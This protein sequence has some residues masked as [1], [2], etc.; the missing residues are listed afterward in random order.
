MAISFVAEAHGTANYQTSISVSKPTG[1]T[2]GDV[3]IAFCGGSP[4]TP[5][6]WT[7][8]GSANSGTNS[9]RTVRLFRKVASGEGSSYTFSISSSIACASIVSYRG[10]SNTTPVDTAHFDIS[11]IGATTNFNTAS[12]TAAT[13]QWGV[14]FAMAYEYGSSSTRTW[15]EGSG[16]ERADYS[17]SN[18]G[19]PDNTNCCVADSNTTLSAGS[20]SRTQTRSSA[21]SGGVSAIVLLNLAGGGVVNASAVVADGAT[22][23]ANNPVGSVGI[24]AN[25]GKA[26]VTAVANSQLVLSGRVVRTDSISVTA[27]CLDIGRRIHPDVV[28]VEVDVPVAHVYYG[29]PPYRTY[30]VPPDEPLNPGPR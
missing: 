27:S 12:V 22:V 25:A 14:S 21:A 11:P 29:A 4:S 19:S 6:G 15:T 13:T 7:L 8:L 26:A 30:R 3:M 20:F 24:G 28:T 17:V 2:D 10:V 23:A 5:S 16:S 9:L 18:S 1:T